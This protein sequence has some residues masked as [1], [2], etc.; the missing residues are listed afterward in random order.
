M[1]NIILAENH[2]TVRNTLKK[3]LEKDADLKI[4]AD[5]AFGDELLNL[6]KT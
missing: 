4:V 2:H 1:I 6:L 5:T 3:I